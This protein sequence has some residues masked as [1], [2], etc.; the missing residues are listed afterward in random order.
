MFPELQGLN[1]AKRRIFSQILM[2]IVRRKVLG[3]MQ[4]GE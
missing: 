4:E 3:V 2:K 1:K